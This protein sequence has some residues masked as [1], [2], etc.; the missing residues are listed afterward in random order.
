MIDYS[1]TCDGFDMVTLLKNSFFWNNLIRSK[2]LL[3]RSW[4]DSINYNNFSFQILLLFSMLGDIIL[5]Y[6]SIAWC[7]KYSFSMVYDFTRLKRFN[8]MTEIN[9][10]FCDMCK[11][12][13]NW[14]K[15]MSK[16]SLPATFCRRVDN[17]HEIAFSQST[18][19]KCKFKQILC[20]L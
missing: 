6:V 2:R 13:P 1:E 19:I 20:H 18:Y 11:I 7:K 3:T 8:F 17:K 9:W 10:Y 5:R 15:K 4:K 14:R 16:H 12:E